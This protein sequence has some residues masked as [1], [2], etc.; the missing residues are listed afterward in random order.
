MT[1]SLAFPLTLLCYSWDVG[2]V[3]FLFW[4]CSRLSIVSTARLSV[5]VCFHT[6]LIRVNSWQCGFIHG[7]VCSTQH[8]RVL[9]RVLTACEADGHF[10]CSSS[11]CREF[12]NRDRR[13]PF[14][15]DEKSRYECRNKESIA[16]IKWSRAGAE[17]HREE[18]NKSRSTHT[19]R[20]TETFGTH[21]TLH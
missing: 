1:T 2:G 13:W 4:W 16:T 20:G 18:M 15:Y 8:A 6:L 14:C 17:K 3:N 9:V 7:S 10:S 11:P 5:A 19:V 21:L 12:D